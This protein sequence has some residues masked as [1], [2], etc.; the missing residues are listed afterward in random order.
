MMLS[1]DCQTKHRPTNHYQN[2]AKSSVHVS[3][4]R[5]LKTLFFSPIWSFAIVLSLLF[6]TFPSSTCR[7]APQRY[8]NF[9]H[10]FWIVFFSF[11][12]V[13]N[14][15]TRAATAEKNS[16]DISIVVEL[17][18]CCNQSR[19]WKFVA[20]QKKTRQ[21]FCFFFHL[22]FQHRRFP[23]ASGSTEGFSCDRLPCTSNYLPRYSKKE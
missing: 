17:E 6:I 10:M 9:Q 23:I 21:S 3:T 12:Q 8:R 4:K 22:N 1:S 11:S 18:N 2:F 16:I 20:V 13:L 19:D 5:K 14:L 15:K 7:N